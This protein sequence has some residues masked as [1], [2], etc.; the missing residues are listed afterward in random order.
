M[1]LSWLVVCCVSVMSRVHV[2]YG[3]DSPVIG[4]FDQPLDGASGKSYIAASY[5]KYMESAGARVVPIHYRS[6]AT[7]LRWLASKLNGVLYTGGGTDLL[8]GTPYYEAAKTVYDAAIAFNKQG[9]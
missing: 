6:N 5:V 2:V 9:D 7:T 8:P 4:I 1:R 3:T